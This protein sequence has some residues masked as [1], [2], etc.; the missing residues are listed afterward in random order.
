MAELLHSTNSRS[1]LIRLVLPMNVFARQEL[2][3]E[4]YAME[5]F[6]KA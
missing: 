2:N 1:S 4:S 5:R 3:K 6:E